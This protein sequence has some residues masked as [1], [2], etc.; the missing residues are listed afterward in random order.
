VVPGTYKVALHL[1]TLVFG[2]TFQ[3]LAD[4]RIKATAA[5]YEEQA[6][7]LQNVATDVNDIHVAVVRMR[8]VQKQLNGI[9]DRIENKE[10]Y[11]SIVALV[12]SINTKIDDWEEKLIQ[13]KS[14]SNDDVINFVNK[15][16]ANY[17]FLRGELDTNTPHVTSGHVNR[18]KE[19]RTEWN[20]Y[21]KAF[22]TLIEQDIKNFNEKCRAFQLPHASLID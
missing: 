17:I 4:P 6:N 22:N 2:Q 13:T 15:L 20:I 18:F 10:A 3:V 7:L 8:N 14:E 11:K 9:V 12:D 19:L 21:K 5:D 1:D 16:S